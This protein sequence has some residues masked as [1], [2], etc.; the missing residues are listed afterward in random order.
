ME[1]LNIGIIERKK[2]IAEEIIEAIDRNYLIKNFNENINEIFKNEKN[3]LNKKNIYSNIVLKYINS[4]KLSYLLRICGTLKQSY[5]KEMNSAYI[6]SL[7]FIYLKTELFEKK[8]NDKNDKEKKINQEKI[9]STKDYFQLIRYFYKNQ[10]INWKQVISI[11]KY[12][13]YQIKSRNN[14]LQIAFKVSNL[15]VF[16]KFLRKLILDIEKYETENEEINKEIKKDIL[17]ELFEILANTKNDSNYSYLMRTMIKEESIFSLVKMVTKYGFLSEE[18]KKY[19]EDN[20]VE[21]LKNNFRKE[22]LN[23]FYKIFNKLLIKFNSFNPNLKED[24][25]KIENNEYETNFNLINKDF[26]FLMKI[27][28]ILIS[29]ITKEQENKNCYYCDKGFVFNNKEKERFGFKVN[30]ICYKKKDINIFC[31]L[32]SFLLKES[33]N[34]DENKIIFSIV[35]S[36]NNNEKLTIFENGDNICIRFWTKKLNEINMHKIEYNK[37]FNFLFFNDKNSIKI[38]INGKDILSEKNTDFKLP[39]KFKVFVGCPEIKENKKNKEYSFNGIIYPILLFELA[40][41]KKK[42]IY[43]IFKQLL[44]SIKNKYYLIAEEY[45]N[46]R[47]NLKNKKEKESSELEKIIHSYEI[48][49]GLGEDLVKQK[50]I[51]KILNYINNLI[52]YI[53]PYIINS[54]FNKKSQSYKDYNT[55]ESENKKDINYFYEFNV[56]PSLEHGKI[57]SFRDY[58]IVSYFKINNGFNLIILEIEALFNYILLLNSKKEFSELLN[59]NKQDFFSKM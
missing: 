16:L 23:F 35:D 13:I 9:I 49:N 32:F 55:Y 10:L 27:N 34:V 36:E 46:H 25:S 57:Y 47:N 53:N 4:K 37:V 20:I 28:E 29:V 43:D 15:S 7:F 39:D 3:Q 58:N 17:D 44:L 11:F 22:H 30:D 8:N 19:I 48:Y 56:I 50:K 14:E 2:T 6:C 54:S 1:S 24:K 33:G 52:L 59:Q 18:N 12:F 45:F 41:Y 38:C 5:Q 21:I 26:S 40:E 31:I 42:D 51:E